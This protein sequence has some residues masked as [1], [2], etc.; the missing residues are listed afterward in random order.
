[1]QPRSHKSSSSP[2][3]SDSVSSIHIPTDSLDHPLPVPPSATSAPDSRSASALGSS[4]HH[5]NGLGLNDS[6]NDEDVA[7]VQ[8][9]EAILKSLCDL[10]VSG[11]MKIKAKHSNSKSSE[12]AILLCFLLVRSSPDARQTQTDER[13][14]SRSGFLSSAAG[15][16]RGRL[17]QADGQARSIFQRLL[18]LL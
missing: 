15:R 12:M 1:M 8:F 4:N 2:Q 3:L 5:A 10:D 17:C 14:V 9:D 13:F 6:S 7:P 16:H 18:C 11:Q